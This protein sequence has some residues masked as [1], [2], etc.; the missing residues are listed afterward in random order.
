MKQINVYACDVVIMAKSKKAVEDL[1]NA[2]NEKANEV[3]LSINQKKTKYLETN[4][5]RSKKN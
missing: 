3:G 1:L 2:L 5:K 4:A